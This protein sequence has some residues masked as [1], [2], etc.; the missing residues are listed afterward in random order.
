MPLQNV[1]FYGRKEDAYPGLTGYGAWLFWQ[2]DQT[3]REAMIAAN[4]DVLREKDPYAYLLVSHSMAVESLAVRLA[5]D[6]KTYS[7]ME[8]LRLKRGVWPSVPEYPEAVTTLVVNI[9]LGEI[10]PFAY[11]IYDDFH[12]LLC[13]PEPRSLEAIDDVISKPES[14]VDAITALLKNGG[15]VLSALDRRNFRILT[16]DKRHK[17]MFSQESEKCE[18]RLLV[19]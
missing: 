17:D 13:L 12:S 8:T 16:L 11:D 5:E 3:L 1:E 2:N 9:G 19:D 7:E 15:F 14:A 4:I 10:L 18:R 6:Q